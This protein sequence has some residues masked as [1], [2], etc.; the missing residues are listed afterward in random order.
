MRYHYKFRAE[1]EADVDELIKLLGDEWGYEIKVTQKNPLFPDV[2]VEIISPL[3]IDEIQNLMR[4]VVDGH[5][6]VQTIAPL[7]SYTGERDLS[8]D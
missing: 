7:D 8:I 2:E 4:K 5:V 1:C 6:M 3:K